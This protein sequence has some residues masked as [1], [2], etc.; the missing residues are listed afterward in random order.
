[1]YRTKQKL[2]VVVTS[3][4]SSDS[5]CTLAKKRSASMSTSPLH[6]QI[7]VLRAVP[8]AAHAEPLAACTVAHDTCVATAPKVVVPSPRP[9]VDIPKDSPAEGPRQR[10]GNLTALPGR[11][12]GSRRF[13]RAIDWSIACNSISIAFRDPMVGQ[14]SCGYAME[15]VVNSALLGLDV[16]FTSIFCIELLLKMLAHGW[17]D[18]MRDGW[19]RIDGLVTVIA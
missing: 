3:H 7:D 2:S 16:G 14:T 8:N 19:N 5:P 9:S 4:G 1:M 17:R 13:E 18:Y 15:P 10:V 11:I 6:I 12:V